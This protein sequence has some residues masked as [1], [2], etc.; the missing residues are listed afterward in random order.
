MT[1]GWKSEFDQELHLLLN[2]TQVK[3]TYRGPYIMSKV[4]EILSQAN[5]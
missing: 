2:G 1:L 5:R 3:S 4:L